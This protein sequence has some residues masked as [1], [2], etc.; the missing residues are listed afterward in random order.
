MSMGIKMPAK[1]LW[2]AMAALLLVVILPVPVHADSQ[3]FYDYINVDINV[4]PNSDMEVAET[5]GFVFTSGTFQFAERWIE[6][7]KVVSIDTVEV[8]EGNMPLIYNPQVKKWIA[9]R[10]E[11]GSAIGG[12]S[13]AFYDEV[14]GNKLW[15]G[16]WFP[17]TGNASRTF[18]IK[19][20]VH[21][22]VRVSSSS[23]QI[24]WRAIFSGRTVPVQR[25][26]VT[27]HFPSVLPK[28]MVTI[29]SYGAP[30]E[31]R[32]VDDKTIEFT[33]G[34]ISA[35]QELEIQVGFPHGIVT[36]VPPAWQI[37]ME[38]REA[39]DR[40]VKPVINIIVTL[41]ALI[42]I[43]LAGIV[44]LV[45]LWRKRGNETKVL[46]PGTVI[47]APDNL[48]PALVGLLVNASVG[49]NELMGTIADLAYH[50]VL[51]IEEIKRPGLLFGSSKDVQ[52]NR[53]GAEMKFTFE[54]LVVDAVTAGPMSLLRTQ[55]RSLLSDFQKSVEYESIGLELFKEEPAVARKRLQVPAIIMFVASFILLFLGVFIS[56]FSET[57]L[58]VPLAIFPVGI[59]ALVMSGRMPVRTEKGARLATYCRAFKRHLRDTVKDTGLSQEAL[60]VWDSYLPYAVVFGLRKTW[61]ARFASMEASAP[62]WFVPMAV[63]SHT[64]S[65]SMQTLPGSSVSLSSI[66]SAFSGVFNS[67][68]NIFSGGS[69]SSG[70]GGGGGGGGSGGGGGGAG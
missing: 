33:S 1:W 35:G 4:L 42:V 68:G 64:T 14:R 21:G 34:A 57:A 16:W 26:K 39:Y 59:A 48:P 53:R 3:Y 31:N 60:G 46:D 36:A 37:E 24:Y 43:P 22:V 8:W 38:R 32:L 25:S 69:G 58:L 27:M 6:L 54:R 49:V 20:T 15:I 70:G 11:H 62:I 10:K 28:D 65:D 41:F 5:Q 2:A 13:Y 63:T 56:Q 61:I 9:D 66:S 23:D 44:W 29:R 67:I 19:Y 50:G 40:D 18:L 17:S 7:D 45:S 55:M 52:I 30:A 12:S 51:E 47:N